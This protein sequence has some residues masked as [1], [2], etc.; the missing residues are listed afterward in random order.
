[1]RLAIL[2]GSRW[3][4]P[5]GDVH[6]GPVRGATPGLVN[7]ARL[8]VP[9]VYILRCGDGSLY[10]GIAKDLRPA[11]RA[12][13]ARASPRGTRAPTCRSSLVWKRRVLTWSGAL[14]EELPDQDA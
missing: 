3:L 14:R 8:I 12:A 1:M 13:P 2:K 11:P 5:R 7:T 9:F 10:T 4:P 6:G